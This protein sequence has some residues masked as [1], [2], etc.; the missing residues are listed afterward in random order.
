MNSLCPTCEEVQE[1]EY[2]DDTQTLVVCL[3][4]GDEFEF[5]PSDTAAV[6][7]A[8]YAGG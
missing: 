6:M 5:T 3:T 1:V 4:C 2:A 7:Y 8:N